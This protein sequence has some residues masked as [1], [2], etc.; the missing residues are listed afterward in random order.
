MGRDLPGA[1]CRRHDAVLALA[2]T[3]AAACP[4]EVAHVADADLAKQ[5]DDPVASLISVPFQFNYDRNFGSGNGHRL[6]LNFQPVIPFGLSANW[7]LISRTIVPLVRQDDIAGSSGSQS[8][9]GDIT[10]SLFPPPVI[11]GLAGIIWRVGPAFLILTAADDLLGDEKWDVG[12]TGVALWQ[13]GSWTAEM[14][15]NHIWSVAGKSDRLDVSATFLQPLLAYILGASTR[16][17][18]RR[19]QAAICRGSAVPKIAPNAWQGM[20]GISHAN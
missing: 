7:N 18:P 20:R 14:L 13:S 8:E 15:A 11:P 5:L 9:P 4:A 16:Q 19:I 3:V 12:P 17:R 1:N 6:L 2:T 10:R